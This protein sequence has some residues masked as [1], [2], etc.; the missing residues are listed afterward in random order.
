MSRNEI[1]LD[2][3]QQRLG[4]S[5]KSRQTQ[6]DEYGYAIPEKT[7]Y[8]EAPDQGGEGTTLNAGFI[9]TIVAASLTLAWGHFISSVARCPTWASALAVSAAAPKP[10]PRIGP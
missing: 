2:Q 9:A 7:L 3:I 1:R 4:G 5:N 10:W 8:D 6:F